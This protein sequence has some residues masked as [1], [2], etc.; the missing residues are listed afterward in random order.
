MEKAL[1]IIANSPGEMSGWVAPV[2]AQ[3]RALL[4]DVHITVALV[5]DWFTS[6]RER[7]FA[8]QLPVD[9]V[10][11]VFTVIRSIWRELDACRARK[12]LVLFLGGDALY[13]KGVAALLKCPA[14][15]YMPRV[16]HPADFVKIFVPTQQEQER[17]IRKGAR[18][19]NIDVVPTLALDSVVP[20]GTP[21]QIRQ[22]LGLPAAARPIFSLMAGSRP[23]YVG[24]SIDFML[25]I[26]GNLLDRYPE[27]RALLPV[28]PFI[29]RELV[30]SVLRQRGMTW[31]ETPGGDTYFVGSGGRIL[32]VF[33][34]SHDAFV[35]AD[36]AVVLPGTN[37]LQC[38]AL[39]VPFIMLM[40]LNSIEHIP[41]EGLLG[42]LYP[43]FFPFTKLKKWVIAWLD[44]RVKCLSMV[45]RMAGRMLAPE[46]R[47]VLTPAGVAD[48]A[49]EL[50]QDTP[51]REKL[52]ADLLELTRERGAARIIA[53]AIRENLVSD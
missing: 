15:A 12:N 49:S 4:P 8:A 2:V 33:A 1:T 10:A 22:R 7:Q 32:I 24:L 37:N 47:G 50:W 45:N 36:I 19:E 38:A 29:D 5:P 46:L 28:S 40:P 3:V 44:K 34:H 13:A 14:M 41:F 17:A 31:R 51:R 20:S 42:F 43:N 25:D 11:G 53:E 39:G 16:Y 21:E 52:R 27:A 18:P 23:S 26:A 30:L 35:V 9:R 48:Y 6:G